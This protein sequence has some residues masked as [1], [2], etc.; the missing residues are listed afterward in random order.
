MSL[1]ATDDEIL[2][3]PVPT[4]ASTNSNMM[5]DCT[6]EW[7]KRHDTILQ[8]KRGED[9]LIRRVMFTI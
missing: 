7:S 6:L 1:V 4:S 8:T 9:M 2:F 3:L 5:S